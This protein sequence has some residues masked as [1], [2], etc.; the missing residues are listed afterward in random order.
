PTLFAQPRGSQVQPGGEV[1]LVA[2]PD[3][4]GR[5]QYIL[6]RSLARQQKEAAM[7]ELKRQRLL[8]KL[9]QTDVSL[10]KRPC[11]DPGQIERRIGKWLGRYPAAERLLEVRVERN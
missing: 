4:K 9:Q 7:L 6:C 8:A 10:R 2:H 11:K 1:K 5:E 3:G